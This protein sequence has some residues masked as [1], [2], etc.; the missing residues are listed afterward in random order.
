MAV[1]WATRCAGPRATEK[2]D[3]ANAP[4]LKAIILAAGRGRRLWPATAD[5]PKC[6]LPLG[7]KTL[8]ERLFSN[9]EVAGVNDAVIVCGYR[10]E[11][12]RE[13]VA[14][15]DGPLQLQLTYN[16]FFAVADNLISL[17]AARSHMDG[18]FVLINGDNLFSPAVLPLLSHTQAPC[19]VT[20]RRKDRYDDDD[21]KVAIR[22]SRIVAI[23]K[24]LEVA[25]TTAES[26]GIMRFCGPG[27]GW[28][29]RVLE[30]CVRNDRAVHHLF[31]SAI[32]EIID[33]QL[34]VSYCDI[35][36]LPCADVDTPEDLERVRGDLDRYTRADVYRATSGRIGGLA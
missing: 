29:R 28:I 15:Y 32:Q 22:N 23:G 11:C 36:L 27:V 20:V 9:L 6:L 26:V 34:C 16:P 35:G 31:P 3:A 21:M 7:S 24:D 12:I 30:E 2:L 13:V 4:R 10:L 33:S 25:E 5:C 14:T 1:R 17:W 8:L 19:C 18:D